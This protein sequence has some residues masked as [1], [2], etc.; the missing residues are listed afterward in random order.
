MEKEFYEL[1]YKI[2]S[3][4]FRGEWYHTWLYMMKAEIKYLEKSGKN[5]IEILAWVKDKIEEEI[6]GI[7]D[8]RN[9]GEGQKEK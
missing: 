9:G 8:L 1:L 4:G 6:E 7:G 3:T 2:G 5:S